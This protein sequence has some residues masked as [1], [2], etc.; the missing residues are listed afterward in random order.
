MDYCWLLAL[1][2]LLGDELSKSIE[3]YVPSI[4]DKAD[5]PLLV[6]R[7]EC[8]ESPLGV[9]KYTALFLGGSAAAKHLHGTGPWTRLPS[10]ACLLVCEC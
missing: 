10:R 6:P 2:H 5:G 8:R 1:Q 3:L 4:S 7:F 9:V